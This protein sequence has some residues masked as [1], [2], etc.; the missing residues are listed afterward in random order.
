[1]VSLD[2]PSPSS[3][4]DDS[5]VGWEDAE[6]LMITNPELEYLEQLT[7]SGTLISMRTDKPELP[8]QDRN[9]RRALTMAINQQELVDDLCRGHADI[10]PFPI[11]DIPEFSD[12]FIPLEELP[13]EASELFQYHPEKAKQLLADAGYPQG[14]TAEIVTTAASVDLLSVIKAYWA[15]IDV[16]LTLNVVE[17]G[18]WTSV[19]YGH[20]YEHMTVG[21]R[22]STVPFR[23]NSFGTG[24]LPNFNIVDD[25]PI[26]EAIAGIFAKYFSTSERNQAYKELIPYLITEANY[27]MLP[28]ANYFRFWQPWVKTY[29]GAYQVGYA[30]Y[31]SSLYYIWYDQDLKEEI[32]GRR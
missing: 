15:E 1:M 19:S 29:H 3:D 12:M 8:Y 31:E 14:F 4:M 26:E 10:L 22:S 5:I 18:V 32:T 17:S 7:E 16:D 21:S 28:A 24:Q 6:G 9:V 27:I 13:A 20:S 23:F 30:D 2:G 11:L 25:P